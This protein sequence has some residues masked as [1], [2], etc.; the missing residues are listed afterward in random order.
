M[1]SKKLSTEEAIALAKDMMADPMKYGLTQEQIRQWAI[2]GYDKVSGI[3]EALPEGLRDEAADAAIYAYKES[4]RQKSGQDGQR[5]A[6][7]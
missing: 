1:E 2:D 5:E 7:V 6:K 4:Q 3:I